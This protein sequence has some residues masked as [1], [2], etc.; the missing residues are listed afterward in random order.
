MRRMLAAASVLAALMAFPARATVQQSDGAPW[1][2]QSIWDRPDREYQWYPPDPPPKRETKKPSPRPKA[3]RMPDIRKAKTVK[4][5]REI[6][7]RL[8][9]IA[10]MNPTPQNVRAYLDA[11]KYAMDKSALFADVARRVVWATPEIDYSLRRPVVTAGVHLQDDLKE[12]AK[13]STIAEVMRTHGVFFFLRSD[14][15]YCHRQAAVLRY[16]EQFYGL[17]V[18]PISLDGGGV[19]EYPSPKPDNG[20]A[21]LLGVSTV[22]ALFLMPRDAAPGTQPVPVGFGLLSGEEIVS[23]IHALTRMQPGQAF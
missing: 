11:N 16:L 20:I 2:E 4:E 8:R 10:V 14:C 19:P 15:P 3:E 13:R 5:A 1:W 18:F 7:E 9:D 21:R 6:L 23:R 22:P 17:E 12:Q